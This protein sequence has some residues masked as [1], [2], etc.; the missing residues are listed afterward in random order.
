[1]ITSILGALRLSRLEN[2]YSRQLH[3]HKRFWPIK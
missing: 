3:I 1:M 2:A